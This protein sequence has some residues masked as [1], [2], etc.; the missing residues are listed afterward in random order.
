[1]FYARCA[2]VAL[3]CGFVLLGSCGAAAFRFATW[4]GAVLFAPRRAGSAVWVTWLVVLFRFCCVGVGFLFCLSLVAVV[5][6]LLWFRLSCLLGFRLPSIGVLVFV[7]GFLARGCR[8]SRVTRRLTRA[9]RPALYI[10]ACPARP[11]YATA[12]AGRLGRGCRMMHRVASV[13]CLP[14]CINVL[15]YNFY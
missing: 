3:G 15:N 6:F 8:R 5:A 10:H 13:V 9:H 14:F 11:S 1:V 7:F 2:P 12:P 4:A